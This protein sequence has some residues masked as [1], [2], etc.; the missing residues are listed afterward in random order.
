MGWVAG[1][2]DEK[3]DNENN[4]RHTHLHL[5]L[6]LMQSGVLS[7]DPKWGRPAELRGNG[8]HSSHLKTRR[9][10][11]IFG[12]WVWKSLSGNNDEIPGFTF[13]HSHPLAFGHECNLR[14]ECRTV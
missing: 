2:D 5:Q 3:C 4:A 12:V 11:A 7:P 8:S 14:G 9:V 13:M 6:R 10:D 1:G